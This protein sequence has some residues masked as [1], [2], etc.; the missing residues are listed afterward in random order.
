MENLVVQID[1]V[2]RVMLEDGLW[3]T[4]LENTFTVGPLQFLCEDRVLVDM[5][6]GFSFTAAGTGQKILGPLVG[7]RAVEVD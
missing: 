5:G 4:V 6:S 2:A 7:L 1:E 3:I